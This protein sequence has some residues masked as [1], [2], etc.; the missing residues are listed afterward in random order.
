MTP[1]AET[2]IANLRVVAEPQDASPNGA[3]GFSTPVPRLGGKRAGMVVFSPYPFD[4]RPCRAAD[5]LLEE[6]MTVDYICEGGD[7]LPRREKRGALDIT[8]LPIQHYRGGPLSYFYQYSAFISLSAA[9]LA[10]R[11]LRRRYDLV[12]IHN[13]PDI[14]VASALIPKLFGAKVILDQHDPMPE[15]M[16]TIFDKSSSSFT[17]RV[18]RLLEKWSLARADLVIAVNE[19]CRKIFSQRSCPVQKIAVVMNSP[20]GEIFPYRPANSYP[21]RTSDRPFV[22]MYHGSLVE[23]NGVELAVDALARVGDRIPHAE[24]RIYGGD[25]AY[26]RRAMEKA[27]RL[28]LEGQ[29]RYFGPRKLEDLVHEIESCDVGV[30]PNQRNTF[31]DINT[32]T[33]LFEYLALGKPVIAPRTPGI[34]DYFTPESLFFFDSGNA[35][36]LAERFEYVAAHPVEAVETAERGQQIYLTHTWARERQGLVD[37]VSGL[38]AAG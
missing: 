9:I 25:S 34:L 26:L 5:A 38:L 28:G 15:L 14:L 6:G 10:W 11:T 8:R 18:I 35:E 7:G 22:I 20:D 27:A 3:A 1:Q 36:E 30:I 19:A 21:V 12:Y 16:M 29:V 33:R 37:R 31:T 17:V 13:M 2:R 4:P 23:R 24:L 32:P